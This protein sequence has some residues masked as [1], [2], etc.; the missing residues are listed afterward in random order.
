MTT[1]VASKF[2]PE[3]DP[4]RPQLGDALPDG[5]TI[6]KVDWRTT[7]DILAGKAPLEDE[8][9]DCEMLCRGHIDRPA[10]VWYVWVR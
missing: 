10:V 9:S 6:Q 5:R 4:D 7:R 8:M 2:N 3:T 1:F